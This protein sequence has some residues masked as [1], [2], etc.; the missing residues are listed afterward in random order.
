MNSRHGASLTKQ[1]F[2]LK[3]A[4]HEWDNCDEDFVLYGIMEFCKIPMKYDRTKFDKLPNRYQ[5]RLATWAKWQLGY[6]EDWDE[7]QQVNPV[8]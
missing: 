1:E 8:K 2:M 6:C 7:R 5:K 4:K 3:S